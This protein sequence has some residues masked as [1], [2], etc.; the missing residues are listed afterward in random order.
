MS[1]PER[2]SKLL[3]LYASHPIEVNSLPAGSIGVLLGLKHTRTG[4]TLLAANDPRRLPP[5]PTRLRGVEV[6]SAVCSVAIELGGKEEER[7]VGEAL[8]KLVRQD[9][10]LRLERPSDEDDR[11]NNEAQTLL[12]GMGPLHLEISLNRLEEEQGVKARSGKMR[13]SMKESIFPQSTA[14]GVIELEETWEGSVVGYPAKVE[15]SVKVS[16]E[17]LT[18]ADLVELRASS[19][20]V[21]ADIN[22]WGGN[23]VFI[24]IDPDDPL[25]TLLPTITSSLFACVTKGGPLLGLPLSHLRIHLEPISPYADI[26]SSPTAQPST[27]SAASLPPPAAYARAIQQAMHNALRQAGPA[28]LEPL[29]ETH[30]SGVGPTDLG[31]VVADLIN[32]GGQIQELGDELDPSSSSSSAKGEA[33]DEVYTPPNWVSPSASIELLQQ[34][35]SADKVMKRTIV[36]VVPL[37]EMSDYAGKLRSLSAGGGTFETRDGGWGEVDLAVVRK[38]DQVE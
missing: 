10:S 23:Q 8:E 3:L 9:P 27:A 19:P 7:I 33:A 2:P 22:E 1:E 28:I 11:A 5:M 12:H 24:E 13:V 26:L 32:R 36:A 21:S 31:K 35:L 29:V 6:P 15:A 18:D 37:A 38:R 16:L 4:D 20:A 30:I 25:H 17:R 14:D 34:G